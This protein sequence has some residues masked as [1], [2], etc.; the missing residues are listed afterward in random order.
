[1]FPVSGSKKAQATS[2]KDSKTP[3][4]DGNQKPEAKNSVA[5]SINLNED[6][7]SLKK[8]LSF[9]L[10]KERDATATVV[11]ST[12]SSPT[13]SVVKHNIS[14]PDTVDSR[15]GGIEMVASIV[16]DD[17]ER[18]KVKKVSP[19][20]LSVTKDIAKQWKSIPGSDITSKS[21]M[22]A[23]QTA[24][25]KSSPSAKDRNVVDLT[26]NPLSSS[27]DMMPMDL[28]QEYASD[29]VKMM[30]ST[31]NGNTPNPYLNSS[32]VPNFEALSHLLD[33]KPELAPTRK[34][35]T[36]APDGKF[37][38]KITSN[39]AN[40]PKGERT[41]K[42][43]QTPISTSK[44]HAQTHYNASVWSP[45]KIS[46]QSGSSTK[47]LSQK[48][49]SSSL[50]G[51]SIAQFHDAFPG[52]ASTVLAQSF[53]LPSATPKYVTQRKQKHIPTSKPNLMLPKTLYGAD[54]NPRSLKNPS[55]SPPGNSMQ[56]PTSRLPY[57]PDNS[58]VQSSSHSLKTP[59][60]ISPIVLSPYTSA[61]MPFSPSF[62]PQISPFGSPTFKQHSNTV[63]S[64]PNVSLQN[65][66]YDGTHSYPQVWKML[67]SNHP[68]FW[69]FY[70]QCLLA[71]KAG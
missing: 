37:Q 59:H 48:F 33:R 9:N 68:L 42:S 38:F 45:K 4:S 26:I 24:V 58:Y 1:M 6:V 23:S 2:N 5:L 13:V 63:C 18:S 30:M 50:P 60:P 12:D 62:N 11:Q 47:N 51:S 10:T 56:V 46:P 65:L 19:K 54:P 29:F 71:G 57:L 34:P 41:Q 43:F 40:A 39:S 27:I 44:N 21:F 70:M 64:Y 28:V 53:A 31:S 15:S 16:G 52:Q 49:T 8:R 67:F 17:F 22:N 66:N 61:G 3:D 14:K 25:S 7:D 36:T 69:K 55:P 35:K 32:G 20:A